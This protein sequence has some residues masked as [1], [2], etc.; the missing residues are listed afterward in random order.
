MSKLQF[1]QN[2]FSV[3]SKTAYD[4]LPVESG[5]ESEEEQV[6]E[7]EQVVPPAVCVEIPSQLFLQVLNLK[8]A[9]IRRPSLLKPPLKRQRRLL[10]KKRN[11][12]IVFLRQELTC[13]NGHLRRPLCLAENLRSAFQLL[14]MDSQ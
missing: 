7:P 2:K 14:Q 5:E 3:S 11:S 10:V 4:L 8:L 13:L 12:R 6:S 9:E 1:Q